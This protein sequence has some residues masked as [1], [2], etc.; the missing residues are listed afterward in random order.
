MINDDNHVGAV[1]ADSETRKKI[2]KECKNMNI[3]LSNLL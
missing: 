3:R 2:A 1:R